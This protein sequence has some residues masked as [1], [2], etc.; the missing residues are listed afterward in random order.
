MQTSNWTA[1]R[2]VSLAFWLAL[3]VVAQAQSIVGTWES[4]DHVGTQ[5]TYSADG[6]WISVTE[7][8]VAEACNGYNKNEGRYSVSGDQLTR[9]PELIVCGDF[10]YTLPPSDYAIATWSGTFSVSGNTLTVNL[11]NGANV[12]NYT[13]AAAG[14]SSGDVVGE[15]L[16][17]DPSQPVPTPV[18]LQSSYGVSDGAMAADAVAVEATGTLGSASLTVSLD[19]DKALPAAFAASGYNAYV[20]ALV[21]G[22]QLGST[23]DQFFTFDGTWQALALPIAPYLQNAVENSVGS[24]V[25][26]ELLR[27]TDITRLIGSEIYVGYGTSDTEM[28]VARRYRGVFKVE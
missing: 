1:L 5:E 14:S 21:P 15:P 10:N 26:V 8:P 22:R 25:I 11:Y 12:A 27:N 20:A 4:I 13:L 18:V 6:K 23:S 19:V 28:L 16:I 17:G 7:G 24:K 3:P 2:A 9:Y